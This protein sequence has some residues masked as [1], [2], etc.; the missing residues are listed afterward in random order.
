[1]VMNELFLIFRK[2]LPIRVAQR[3]YVSTV[4]GYIEPYHKVN[5][6]NIIYN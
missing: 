4:V 5:C 1:M 3:F 6:H 2:E